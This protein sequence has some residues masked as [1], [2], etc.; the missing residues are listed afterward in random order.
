MSREALLDEF[1]AIAS[2]LSDPGLTERRWR[3]LLAE[4]RVVEGKLGFVPGIL[5]PFVLVASARGWR[6]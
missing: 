4:A 3:E 6:I 1:R 2:Q 5:E